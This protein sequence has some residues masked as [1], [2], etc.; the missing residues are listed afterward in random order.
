[1]NSSTTFSMIITFF[2]FI[3]SRLV[4]TQEILFTAPSS[5]SPPNEI[6]LYETTPETVNMFRIAR[7]ILDLCNDAMRD[8]M[9]SKVPGGELGLTKKIASSKTYLASSRLSKDQERLLFPPNNAQVQY[10]S[11][12]FTLM[13]ALV[14]NI[15]HE[16]IEPNSKKNNKWG[17][18]PTAGEVGLVVAIESIRGCRNA[19]FAHASSTKVDKKTFDELWTTIEGAVGEIDNHIDRSVTRVCYK[20]EMDKMK[21]DPIDPQL[22]QILKIQIEKEKE[23]NELLKM[24][25]T[26]VFFSQRSSLIF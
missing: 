23:I 8:L 16:E 18:R 4:Q 24:E 6:L 14:R 21:T 2:H 26:V 7:L 5:D 9:Q 22:Q 25:G 17:K 20:K 1:M 3:S 15:F 19:F 10:Q 11:L 13:Y 12:D